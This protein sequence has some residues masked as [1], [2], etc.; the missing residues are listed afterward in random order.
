MSKK[1]Y[2]L[3]VIYTLIGAISWGFS[4]ASGQYLLKLKQVDPQWLTSIRLLF[5][6]ISL[7]VIIYLYKKNNIFLIFKDKKS[8]LN[9]IF[10]GIVGLM[11]CQYTYFVTIN[12][13]NAAIAT[14]LQYIAPAFI[15][16]YVSYIKRKMP[17]KVE[18][19]ALI[20]AFVG[21]YLLAT[22][23]KFDLNIPLNALLVGILSA[24]CV[25]IYSIAPININKTY[26]TASSLS[27]GL[28]IG[29]FSLI[30]FTDN[31]FDFSKIDD[32]SSYFALF[33]VIFFGTIIA[34]STYMLGVNIIGPSRASLIAS[35]EPIAAAFFSFIWVGQ[36]FIYL[37]FIGFFLIISCTI[38]LSL[39][40][41]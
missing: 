29:S 4:G 5:S 30:F 39:N 25:S 12:L 35:V 10:Y 23:G 40:K 26:G 1:N 33:G 14:V 3:G 21:V 22:H 38:L 20:L 13:S 18:F 6:G 28:L 36:K 9:L 8:L 32:F 37:D 17:K 34:F 24:I 41:N 7:F 15:M 27:L 16:L 19:I 2:T 31:V 11:L